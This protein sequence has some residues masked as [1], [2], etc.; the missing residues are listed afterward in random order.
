MEDQ[1]ISQKKSFLGVW[2]CLISY[3]S[4]GYFLYN[5]IFLKSHVSEL[6]SIFFIGRLL[7]NVLLSKFDGIKYVRIAMAV[8]ILA[9][10]H[11][12]TYPEQGNFS[13]FILGLVSVWRGNSAYIYGQNCID[14]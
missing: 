9:Y 12:T 8:T 13:S 10:A 7:G 11:A 14:K 3:C 2:A 6:G 5:L 1:Y 4:E